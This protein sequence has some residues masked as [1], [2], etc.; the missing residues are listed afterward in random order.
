MNDKVKQ[1]IEENIKLIEMNNWE[2]VYQKAGNK[3]TD[4]EFGE[5]TKILLDADIHPEYRLSKLPSCFLCATD[6]SKFEIPDS[7]TSI[8]DG[9]FWNCDSLTSVTIGNGVSSVGER[10]FYNCYK[11]TSVY[12]TDIAAWCN[13]DFGNGYSNPLYYA[14]NIYLNGDLITDLVIPNG[15]TAIKDYAFL[16]CSSLTSVTI[17]DSVTAIGEDAFYNCD[18]LTSVILGNNVKSIGDHAF[19]ECRDNLVINYRGSK[20]D[21]LKIYNTDAFI[22]TYFTVNCIDGKIIKRKR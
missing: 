15:V 2:E 22:H 9:A 3:F 13:I 1:F 16:K 11:L 10:S 21:W 5:F 18:S 7:I 19:E 17:P 8:G 14:K 6:I 4:I 12:I 20:E